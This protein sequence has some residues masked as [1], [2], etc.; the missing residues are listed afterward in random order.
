MINSLLLPFGFAFSLAANPSGYA[1][2]SPDQAQ[3]AG[4]GTIVAQSDNSLRGQ[5]VVEGKTFVGSA[6]FYTPYRDR[7][8]RADRTLMKALGQPHW[9]SGNMLLT[10][11]D[12]ST[13]SCSFRYRGVYVGGQ[14]ADLSLETAPTI[15]KERP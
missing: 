12:G 13:L 14:C 7:S 11:A 3:S 8:L 4:Q 10:A 15:T 6:H 2:V 1:L 9:Q 5:A